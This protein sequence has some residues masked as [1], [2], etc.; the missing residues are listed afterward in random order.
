MVNGLLTAL[1]LLAGKGNGPMSARPS[2]R[3]LAPDSMQGERRASQITRHDSSLPG[4]LRAT[5][6]PL[7]TRRTAAIVLSGAALAAASIAFENP[8]RATR[9]L[10]RPPW[11]QF[12]DIGN[13]YG[14]GAVLGA[15]VLTLFA[16]GSHTGSTNV[17]GAGLEATRSLGAA[18]AATAVLK[19]A[20][21]RT[22]PDGGAY[23]FPSGHAAGAFAVAPVLARHFGRKAAIPAY[24]L[25]LMTGLGRLEDRKHY[26][27][28]VIFGA[29]LGTAAG[30]AY[31]RAPDADHPHLRVS[32][33]GDKAALTVRF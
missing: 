11:E 20:V 14:N 5:S 33:A 15:G 17:R 29:T 18:F 23:S 31:S 21:R 26:L 8:E 13:V 10:D 6:A 19:L 3:A 25:A 2:A 16:V 9:A 12:A 22:R 32:F 27:S 24:A 1:L 28:D 30:L 7:L 4:L